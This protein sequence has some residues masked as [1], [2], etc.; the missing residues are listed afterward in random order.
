M[1]HAESMLSLPLSELTADVPRY[2][3]T[4]LNVSTVNVP[5]LCAKMAPC[6]PHPKSCRYENQTQKNLLP[7]MDNHFFSLPNVAHSLTG[8]KLL[9]ILELGKILGHKAKIHAL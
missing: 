7:K 1:S 4:L 6:Q 9:S 5:V 2:L 3:R 8:G